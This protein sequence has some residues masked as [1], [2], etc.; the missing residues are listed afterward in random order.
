MINKIKY[1]AIE[2]YI[3]LAVVFLERSYLEVCSI[4]FI[5]IV[6]ACTLVNAGNQYGRKVSKDTFIGIIL[7]SI[8]LI[9]IISFSKWSCSN[10]I[11]VYAFL[12]LAYLEFGYGETGI[13]SLSIQK[14]FDFV[15]AVGLL[16]Y[17][18]IAAIQ[19]IS[20]YSLF[21]L[22]AAWDKNYTGITIFLMLVYF[23]KRKSLIGILSCIPYVFTLNS[24]LFQLCVCLIIILTWG[25]DFFVKHRFLKRDSAFFHLK[26]RVI[27]LIILISTIAMMVVSVIWTTRISNNV[28]N[29]Y[30]SSL[31]DTSNA[32]RTRSNIY[33]MF[34][35]STDRDLLFYGYDDDIKQVLGVEDENSATLFAGYRLVQPHNFLLNLWL[36]HG[37]IFSIVYIYLISRLISLYWKKENIP[38]LITYLVANMVMHSLLSTTY[39]LL[40]FFVICTKEKNFIGYKIG[41]RGQI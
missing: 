13:Q 28:V 37:M 16:I 10:T 23:Y 29:T 1:I 33:A 14:Y 22:P 35:I 30:Q 8:S 39:L 25:L 15:F 31:N 3:L 5:C 2:L 19:N 12:I 24:R 41:L 21:I 27:F 6:L 36:K 11:M 20:D 32:I 7:L 34:L 4:L 9:I 26:T 17:W 40:F 38:L 18:L